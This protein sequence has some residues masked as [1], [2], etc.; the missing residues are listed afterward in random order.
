[1]YN[2]VLTQRR[3][4]TTSS[5]QPR[6]LWN[7]ETKPHWFDASPCTTLLLL[8]LAIYLVVNISLLIHV[9]KFSYFLLLLLSSGCECDININNTVVCVTWFV[10]FLLIDLSNLIILWCV[11]P[12][13][14]EA[15][16]SNAYPK[17]KSGHLKKSDCTLCFKLF[18]VS[19]QY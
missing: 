9:E 14:H 3:E 6:W 17:I 16:V 10:S 5:N 7:L 8:L 11:F 2:R 13:A 12:W 15:F 18:S 4:P 19:Q 1:M